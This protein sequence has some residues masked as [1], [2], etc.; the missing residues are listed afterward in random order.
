MFGKFSLFSPLRVPD[1][2]AIIFQGH[3]M[4]L[5]LVTEIASVTCVGMVTS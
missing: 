5:C 4:T 1:C 2:N 3:L